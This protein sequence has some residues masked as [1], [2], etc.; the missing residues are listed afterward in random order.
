MKTCTFFQHVI[1]NVILI[2]GLFVSLYVH[3]VVASENGNGILS[4]ANLHQWKN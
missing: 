2:A 1:L 4:Y 3:K